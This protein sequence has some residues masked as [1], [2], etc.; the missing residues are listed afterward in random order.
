MSSQFETEEI[1]VAGAV[2]EFEEGSKE[3]TWE[4]KA[5]AIS[6]LEP[7]EEA[8]LRPSVQASIHFLCFSAISGSRMSCADEESGGGQLWL[9]CVSGVF[10]S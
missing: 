4:A 7:E 10:W 8:I 5:R 9:D 2:V 6:E 3:A 1:G